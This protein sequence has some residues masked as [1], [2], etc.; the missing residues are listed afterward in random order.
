MQKALA[1]IIKKN[2]PSQF[3][4]DIV[5]G[6]LP[7]GSALE[8]DVPPMFKKMGELSAKAIGE[9]DIYPHST[10]PVAEKIVAAFTEAMG[11]GGEKSTE[12]LF[13]NMKKGVVK[14]D[15]VIFQ[16]L[17]KQKGF[18]ADFYNS[19]EKQ[20]VHYGKVDE[21]TKKKILDATSMSD[22]QFEVLTS[23]STR[24]KI[25]QMNTN[26]ELAATI[27]RMATG[28]GMDKVS[29]KSKD[30]MENIGVSKASFEEVLKDAKSID[31]VYQDIEKRTFENIFDAAEGDETS[32]V[33]PSSPAKPETPTP[34]TRESAGRTQDIQ[35]ARSLLKETKSLIEKL[36]DQIAA[37]INK[38]KTGGGQQTV[39]AV[40]SIPTAGGDLARQQL[41]K[42]LIGGGGEF[43]LITQT[44]EG[45]GG[46]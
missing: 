4:Q 15:R 12:A 1:Y 5:D 40:L 2:S 16:S 46:E 24:S 45:P 31:G 7:I 11:K 42:A 34:G 14:G 43:N 44:P 20:G 37:G 3:G 39:N 19:L 8:K 28:Q 33:S 9:T 18:F 13:D 22:K 32:A 29:Q 21:E 41:I 23:R 10:P 6:I 35:N 26:K 17:S 27:A 36:P 30:F 38:S 25:R